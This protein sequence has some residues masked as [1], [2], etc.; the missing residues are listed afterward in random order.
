VYTLNTK[1]ENELKEFWNTWSFLS[2]RLE[3]LRKGGN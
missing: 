1:G 2:E 3:E